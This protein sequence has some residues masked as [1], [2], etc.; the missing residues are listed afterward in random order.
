MAP[1]RDRKDAGHE[2]GNLLVKL[3]PDLDILVL[4]LP[5]GGVVVGYE[6]ARA[7]R[8]E[9]DIFLVRKLGMPGDEEFAIGALASG[10][11]RVLNEEA[12]R[13]FH[14]SQEAID[15]VTA[16]EQRELQRREQVYREGRAPA[17]ISGR[18][19]VVVDDGLATGS[20]MLAACR[21]VRSAGPRRLVAAVPVGSRQAC[22]NLRNVTDETICAMTPEPF[23]AIGSWYQDF[24]QT[25]DEE[26]RELL[27]QAARERAS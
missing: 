6:V 11:I 2:L 19:V 7:L 26:V 22:R 1:Y 27:E 17:V 21:A 23:T 20:T 25:T 3:L 8:A 15:H 4:A 14:V 5:R 24:R 18:T 9:L 10:G 13:K 12:V 16:R